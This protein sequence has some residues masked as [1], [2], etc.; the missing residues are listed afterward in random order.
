MT[1]SLP[2]RASTS[3]WYNGFVAKQTLYLFVGY[4]GAGKTTIA[5]HIHERTGAVHIWADKERQEMFGEPQH[6]RQENDKLYGYLN[7]KTD[8]L[9]ASGQSVIFDTNFNFYKDRQHLKEIAG[10]H[11]AETVVVWVRTPKELAKKRAVESEFDSDTRLFG[12][13]S[14]EDFERIAGHLQ[15]PD[16]NEKVIKIDGTDL[17]L[18][19]VQRLLEL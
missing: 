1:N 2:T 6:N 10:K 7:E 15:E 12:N 19:E 17:D 13:M 16:E 4:P 3:N 9:L 18:D 5:R 14:S 11:G 8:Q